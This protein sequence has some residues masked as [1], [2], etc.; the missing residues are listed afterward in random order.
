MKS[1][2]LSRLR[3]RNSNAAL[4]L[5]PALHNF[6]ALAPAN[7]FDGITY[8]QDERKTCNS[9]VALLLPAVVP[10]SPLLHHSY[11]KMRV[12][13]GIGKISVDFATCAPFRPRVSP[14]FSTLSARP[15]T[16][17]PLSNSFRFYRFQTSCKSPLSEPYRMIAFQNMPVFS[18]GCLSTSTLRFRFTCR[19]W[20]DIT[21]CLRSANHLQHAEADGDSTVPNLGG[22]KRGIT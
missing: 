15:Y 6:S 9:F 11:E 13:Y 19:V 2:P 3:S 5:Q 18:F 1:S 17:S 20:R 14:S 16:E 12:P 8:R 10:V 4:L 21:P 22:K 7:P